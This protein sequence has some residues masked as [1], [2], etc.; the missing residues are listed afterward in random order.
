MIKG[1]SKSTKSS[2]LN[3]RKEEFTKTMPAFKPIQEEIPINKSQDIK[4]EDPIE[5]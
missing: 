4:S 3:E 2:F 1:V 5:E